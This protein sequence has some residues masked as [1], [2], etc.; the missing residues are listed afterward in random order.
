[1]SSDT[2][3]WLSAWV[4]NHLL[5][6]HWS[7]LMDN[8]KES[9][10]T[11]LVGAIGNQ[12]LQLPSVKIDHLHPSEFP[13]MTRN[14][15]HESRTHLKCILENHLLCLTAV[16]MI[17]LRL[18]T[19]IFLLFPSSDFILKFIELTLKCFL[20][21]WIQLILLQKFKYLLRVKCSGFT[22]FEGF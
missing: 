13:P 8:L 22:E 12:G 10:S 2:W 18:Y 5:H 21:L 3:K 20:V 6:E 4:S 11:A 7:W 16:N 14:H 15:E 19:I 17:W 1:M 9:G